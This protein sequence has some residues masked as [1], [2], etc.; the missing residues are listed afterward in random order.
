MGGGLGAIVDVEFGQYRAH[1][2]QATDSNPP[3]IHQIAL[4]IVDNVPLAYQSGS[5]GASATAT[6][7]GDNY[8]FTGTATGVDKTNMTGGLVSKPF[9]I[10]VTCL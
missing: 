4:G 7:D 3:T 8:K 10:D 2:V 1:A 9:E 6:H 5:P